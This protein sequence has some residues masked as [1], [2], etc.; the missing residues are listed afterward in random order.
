MWTVEKRYRR[1]EEV[2][3]EEISNLM[4]KVKNC[5]W[6]QTFHIQ[7]E[8]GLL[9]DPNG[10]S[11]YNGEYHLFYQWFPLG[12]VHGLKYW[13]HKKSKDLVNWE[14]VGIAIRPNDYFDSHGAYSGSAIEHNGN[15]YFFYTGNTRD[16]N[17]KRHPYQCIA[18]MDTNGHITKMEKPVISEIP[19]GYTDHF[20][21]PK[22]WKENDTFYAVFGAQRTEETG[23]ILLYSSLDLIEW[24]FEGEVGTNLEKFGFMWECPDYFELQNQGVLVFSPQGIEP[25]GDKFQ[26]IYQSGYVLG[27]RLDL[28]K[29]VLEHGQFIEL[30]RGFD[31]YAPQTMLDPKGRRILV[32]WMGLPEIDY[33]TDKNEW[34]HCLTIPRELSIHEG[35]LL[36]KPIKELEKLRKEKVEIDTEIDNETRRFKGFYGESYELSAEFTNFTAEEFGIELRVGENEKTTIKYDSR[37]KQVIFDRSLSGEPVGEAFGTE[38]KCTIGSSTLTFRIFV[39]TSSIELF[40]NDG[41]EVFTGRIFPSK[42]SQG[43][44]FYA[45][46]GA[47][48]LETSL[49]QLD[50]SLNE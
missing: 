21:D 30:D 5:P 32:G 23:C 13:Y 1:I 47:V 31:F 29:K 33:P 7:P 3:I 18:V 14:N 9:N 37:T 25:E 2:E 22:V 43:I 12:P 41:E 44:Q 27:E 50:N 46:G 39:D 26:N 45:K 8:I 34:A 36:Q 49:W 16:E 10:F 35:K 28:E 38:R 40:I 17:W 6:R 20:R 42:E 24:T 15:L 48:N 11:F 4:A 19:K